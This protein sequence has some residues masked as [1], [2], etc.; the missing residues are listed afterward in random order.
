MLPLW[1]PFIASIGHFTDF[2]QVNTTVT[3]TEPV[4]N[5][6][7]TTQLGTTTIWMASY[8]TGTIIQCGTSAPTT[9]P[10]QTSVSVI[11]GNKTQISSTGSQTPGPGNGTR[12]PN[13]TPL[14]GTTVTTDGETFTFR[15]T[16][17][18]SGGSSNLSTGPVATTFTMSDGQTIVSSSGVIVVGSDTFTAPTAMTTV[19]TDGETLTFSPATS[20]VSSSSLSTQDGVTTI[21]EPDG[22]TVISSSGVIIIGTDSFTVPSLT[23]SSQTSSQSQAVSTTTGSD[24]ANFSPPT[25]AATPSLP[26]QASLVSASTVI[27]SPTSS[28]PTATATANITSPVIVPLYH[29]QLDNVTYFIPLCSDPSQTLW[30]S[31]GTNFTLDCNGITLPS[32]DEFPIPEDPPFEY[33]LKITLNGVSVCFSKRYDWDT[34][35]GLVTCKL[36]SESSLFHTDS[37]GDLYGNLSAIADTL[38]LVKNVAGAVTSTTEQGIAN[39]A[40]AAQQ[41]FQQ[42]AAYYFNMVH[43]EMNIA[44]E[45]WHII[46]TFFHTILGHNMKVT[47][48]VSMWIEETD[49]QLQTLACFVNTPEGRESRIWRIMEKHSSLHAGLNTLNSINNVV[50]VNFVEAVLRLVFTG[51]SVNYQQYIVSA[52]SITQAWTQSWRMCTTKWD[53]NSL[54]RPEDEEPDEDD[55]DEWLPRYQIFTKPDASMSQLKSLEHAVGGGGWEISSANPTDWIKGYVVDLNIM[56]ATLP[57]SMPFVDSVYRFVWDGSSGSSIIQ[58]D[59]STSSQHSML[60]SSGNGTRGVGPDKNGTHTSQ[61]QKR[62]F[63]PST[64]PEPTGSQRLA[65]DAGHYLKTISQQKGQDLND[66]TEYTYADPQGEDTWIIVIDSGFD[67]NH[68]KL[69]STNY[70]KVVTYVVPNEYALPKLSQWEVEQ[71]W[72]ESPELIDDNLPDEDAH[73]HGTGVACIAAGL[74]TGVASRANLLLVKPE[75]FFVNKRTNE[76]RQPG[77]TLS[78]IQQA[79]SGIRDLINEHNMGFGKIVI[80]L[81]MVLGEVSRTIFS[82]HRHDLAMSGQIFWYF[83]RH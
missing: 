77:I 83:P 57:S 82:R 52:G 61:F 72:E 55:E 13:T 58:D 70:R 2:Q 6:T 54:E 33:C 69:Q 5:A 25:V 60:S 74:D 1:L 14:P 78:G 29:A 66:F 63:D 10:G 27:S 37:P 28:A 67:V 7:Y 51:M 40:C 24:W 56:Q 34:D 17:T 26:T 65:V 76:K 11:P 9:L 68:Q 46:S 21:T 59:P 73:G 44:K 16:P 19:T 18:T 15:P 47:V 35:Q 75:N 80:N 53:I 79:F 23:T 64:Y 50:D 45:A 32:G 4:M 12:T 3:Y 41:A 81:S 49:R 20:E 43:Q 22:K 36:A 30:R 42:T 48:P 31:D 8:D 38:S 62:D 71:G 39:V